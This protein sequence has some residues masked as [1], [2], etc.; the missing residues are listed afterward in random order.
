MYIADNK[1]L[2]S[3]VHSPTNIKRT[4]EKTKS[5]RNA[6]KGTIFQTLGILT[7][8]NIFQIW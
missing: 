1:K 8:E 7:T 3:S 5:T 6:K 4:Y 2:E